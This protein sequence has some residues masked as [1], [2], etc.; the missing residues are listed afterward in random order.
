MLFSLELKNW[1]DLLLSG[2]KKQF[3][4]IYMPF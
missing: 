4:G 1:R 2:I 3:L